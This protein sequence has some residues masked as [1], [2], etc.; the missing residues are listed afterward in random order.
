MAR[1]RQG[2]REEIKTDRNRGS[3]SGEDTEKEVEKIERGEA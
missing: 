3:N 2:D 1:Y